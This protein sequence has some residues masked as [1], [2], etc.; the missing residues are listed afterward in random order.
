MTAIK[1]VFQ[2]NGEPFYPIGRH[3]IYMAGY[4]VRDDSEI[5]ANFKAS[6]LCDA[7]TVCHAIF[8]DQLEPE[9]GK[10]DFSSIDTTISLAR[11]YDLKLIFLWFATWKNGVMD[12]APEYIKA[13]PK[14]Y[15]RVTGPSG[16]NIWVLSSHCK[17]NLEADK[18]AFAALCKHLKTVDGKEQTVIA[19][20]VENEP[21]ICGSDR[22]YGPE[23]QTEYNSPVPAKLITAM[24]KAGKGKVYD[25]WQ[26]AG[27]GKKSGTWPELFGWEGGE[28]M[29][30]LSI[31]SFINE[32]AKAGKA[33]Y[34]IPM[35]INVAL[36]AP[37]IPGERYS[38]GAAV[39]KTID[40][41]TWFAPYLDLFAPDNFG[42]D[43]RT[44]ELA[45]APFATESNPLLIVESHPNL[46]GMFDD[47]ANFNAIGYFV[48]Y[49]QDKDGVIPP[50]HA[51]RVLLTRSV[52]AAVPLLL[53]YQG[54]GKI[55]AVNEPPVRSIRGRA[56]QD[57]DLDGYWATIMFGDGHLKELANEPGNGLVIQAN[58]HEF[59]L[60]GFNF[61]FMLRPKPTLENMQ[62]S[63]HGHDMDHPS[64]I[65]FVLRVDEGRFNK[66]G[67]FISERRVNG[68]DLRGGIWCATDDNVIR[69]LTCD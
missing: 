68:D 45:N 65:N 51:R 66:K 26:Q 27:G 64:Y 15:Q 42:A 56:T 63:L 36:G 38:S 67:K 50:E 29:T 14:K 40:I 12:Y 62:F 49:D 21:G 19:L 34:N 8:W 44:H 20:Q 32:V 30:A 6:K 17:A 59:Y 48:H 35:F 9:E 11:K 54:T 25:I 3:R 61:R 60:A 13:N 47:I 2:V 57:M 7:N 24:N 55:Q 37:G 23:A 10:F 22:D 31:A 53:K 43:N 18:R 69:I 52:A 33:I 46:N 5:E 28:I 16:N 58:K 4:H 1:R 39:A 41:Y